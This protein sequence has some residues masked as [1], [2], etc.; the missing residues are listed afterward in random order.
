M[1]TI[2]TLSGL[3][4]IMTLMTLFYG[5]KFRRVS[6]EIFNE[7]RIGFYNFHNYKGDAIVYVKELEKYDNGMS[8]IKLKKIEIYG[9]RYYRS[10]LK[11]AIKNNFKSLRD[12]T[13]IEWLEVKKTLKDIRKEKLKQINKFSK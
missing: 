12:S 10:E 6:K 8:K 9:D 13:D 1:I 2:Y 11:T 3:L 4:V 5:I 7:K